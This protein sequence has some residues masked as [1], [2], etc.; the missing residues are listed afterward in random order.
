MMANR[1]AHLLSLTTVHTEIPSR[2]SKCLHSSQNTE[3]FQRVHAYILVGKLYEFHHVIVFFS[4][5]RIM[6]VMY[7]HVKYMLNF[8]VMP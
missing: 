3:A 6:K 5:Y 8:K 2:S 4:S 7:D 1:K